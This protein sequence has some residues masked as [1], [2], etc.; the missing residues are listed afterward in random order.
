[1]L[2]LNTT[3]A[4]GDLEEVHSIRPLSGHYLDS[5]SCQQAAFVHDMNMQSRGQVE[6]GQK[7]PTPD[8][9]VVIAVAVK[10]GK[11]RLYSELELG[12]YRCQLHYFVHCKHGGRLRKVQ[13]LVQLRAGECV[14]A[15][16]VLLASVLLVWNDK[17]LAPKW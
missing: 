15:A 12:C 2:L 14:V 7:A 9:A 5:W 4:V 17:D 3:M 16:P 11:M 6:E 10:Q 1:V 13:E 8:S